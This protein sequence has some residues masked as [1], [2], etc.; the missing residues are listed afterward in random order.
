MTVH[1]QLEAYVEQNRKRFEDLLGQ[2]VNI[3]SI[4]MDP[5]KANDMRLMA[6]LARQVLSDVGAEA[7]IVETG[8]YPFVSGGWI[9]GAHYPTVTVYNHMDVQPAQEPEWRQDP[10]VFQNEG[11]I[12]RGRGAT[13]DKGPA[14][15]ALFGACFVIDQGVPINIHFLWELEEEIGSP[16]LAAGLKQRAEVPRPDSVV[17]SDTIWIAKGRPA[18][19]YGLRGLITR[20][21][22]LENRQQ[23]RP[24]RGNWWGRE[25]SVS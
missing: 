15:S 20:E 25:K 22:D 23:R 3:P 7:Q 21:A 17:V 8:G 12:Y 14:L 2:M 19:P 16:H 4:S 10:F 18:M 6:T 13:D 9:T 5:A 1:H 11:G 24:F